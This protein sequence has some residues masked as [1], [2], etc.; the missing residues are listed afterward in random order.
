M[1]SVTNVFLIYNICEGS[2][3][4]GGQTLFFYFMFVRVNTTKYGYGYECIEKRGVLTS[5]PV[6]RD[7][8]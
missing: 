7:L 6:S 4:G 8:E 5:E 1:L 2:G 3:G